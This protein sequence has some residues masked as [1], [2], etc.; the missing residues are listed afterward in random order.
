VNGLD[1]VS[2]MTDADQDH[3][4]R[5]FRHAFFGAPTLADHFKPTPLGHFR[6]ML[7][8]EAHEIMGCAVGAKLV[9]VNL[10]RTLED[11][12]HFRSE[13]GETV[14]L[15]CEPDSS[16]LAIRPLT[17]SRLEAQPRRSSCATHSTCGVWGNMS[18]GRTL[19]NV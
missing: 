18:T 17:R 4:V 6:S 8:W 5:A 1:Q 16:G 14:G 19:V 13:I 11:W 2:F 3:V 15:D 7:R 10:N 9:Q 12:K